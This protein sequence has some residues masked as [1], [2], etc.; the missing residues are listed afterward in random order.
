MERLGE[1][2]DFSGPNQEDSG[3]QQDGTDHKPG[4]GGG[5]GLAPEKAR[6]NVGKV[7]GVSL[8]ISHHV[9]ESLKHLG[10]GWRRPEIHHWAT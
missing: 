9:T 2:L 4:M 3:P 1:G 5:T 10:W 6:V 8:V 7:V